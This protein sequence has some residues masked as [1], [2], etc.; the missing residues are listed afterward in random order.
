MCPDDPVGSAV[1]LCFREL[2]SFVPKIVSNTK[3][4]CRHCC[5]RMLK[6]PKCS[7]GDFVGWVLVHIP[8]MEHLGSIEKHKKQKQTHT[9]TRLKPSTC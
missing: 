8:Y 4:T 2:R 1:R 9:K 5:L 3:N 7:M 6:K